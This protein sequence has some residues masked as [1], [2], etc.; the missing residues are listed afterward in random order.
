MSTRFVVVPAVLTETETFRDGVRFY[1]VMA[2]SS[3]SIYD[4]QKKR[5]WIEPIPCQRLRVMNAIGSTDVN[6]PCRTVSL[7]N[8]LD[9][10]AT[11]GNFLVPTRH[12]L[13]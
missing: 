3:F 8:Q 6:E 5:D 4:T 13:V 1:S 2:K 10:E 11:V 12:A 9:S 7:S